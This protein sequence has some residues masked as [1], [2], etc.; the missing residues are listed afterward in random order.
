MLTTVNTI[1]HKAQPV[2][3]DYSERAC[4][5]P[6][7]PDGIERYRLLIAVNALPGSSITVQPGRF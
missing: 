6:A 7:L 2:G 1:G 5:D 4:D 3:A